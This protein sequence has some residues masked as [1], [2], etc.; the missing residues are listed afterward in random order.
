MELMPLPELGPG[1]GLRTWRT[2]PIS[3]ETWLPHGNIRMERFRRDAMYGA[4][5]DGVP[6][7]LYSFCSALLCSCHRLNDLVV[8]SAHDR[9]C[10]SYPVSAMIT[11]DKFLESPGGWR[12]VIDGRD[13]GCVPDT[14]SAG[15]NT[16]MQYLHLPTMSQ[17]PHCE[18]KCSKESQSGEYQD[19]L[20]SS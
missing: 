20:A 8:H 16:I 4:R 17:G 5:R 9:M 15:I 7:K 14:V 1:Q 18:H 2:S 11:T 3:G 19:D 6:A 13:L 10:C 12:L